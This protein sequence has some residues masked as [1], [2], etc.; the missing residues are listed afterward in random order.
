MPPTIAIMMPMAPRES[1]SS[2]DAMLAAAGG[3]PVELSPAGPAYRRASPVVVGIAPLALGYLQ[4]ASAEIAKLRLPSPLNKKVVMP[5]RLPRAS[6]SPPPD[7][8]GAIGAV[9]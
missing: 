4:N 5:S 1:E 9:V 6:N 8:P 3:R 2:T 7:D